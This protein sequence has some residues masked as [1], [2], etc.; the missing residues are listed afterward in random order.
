[1]KSG[2]FFKTLICAYRERVTIFFYSFQVMIFFMFWLIFCDIEEIGGMFIT[3]NDS[4]ISFDIQTNF[5]KQLFAIYNMH[6]SCLEMNYGSSKMAYIHEPWP[7]GPLTKA[8]SWT[9]HG[10]S[11]PLPPASFL[12]FQVWATFIT[13]HVVIITYLSKQSF[14]FAKITSSLF[15]SQ[16]NTQ[17]IPQRIYHIN[18]VVHYYLHH[19]VP[20]PGLGPDHIPSRPQA[21]V[22]LW[23]HHQHS[24]SNQSVHPQPITSLHLRT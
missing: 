12:G 6:L 4:S 14:H 13:V 20:G 19:D 17:K 9:H 22:Q 2:P 24:T 18:V 1:M 3:M 23:A 7:P 5:S 16:V 8:L 21:A 10:P 15:I 11:S